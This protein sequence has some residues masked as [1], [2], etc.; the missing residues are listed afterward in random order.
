MT[1]PNLLNDDGTASMATMFMMS[2]HAFRRDL[3]CFSRALSKVAA[4][5]TSRVEAL[6]NE[7]QWYHG[8][9]HGHH[10]MEDGNVFPGM[11]KEHPELAATIERLSSDHHK[12]DPILERG[13]RAFAELP[14]TDAAIGVVNELIE[15]LEPHL[16]LEE[17]EIVPFLRQAKAF[18]A[19]PTE[20]EAAMYAQGFAWSLHGIAPQ[21]VAEVYK[22]LP[23]ALTSRLPEARA[24]FGERC[25][26]AWGSAEA[27]ASLTPIPAS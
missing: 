25:V 6:R 10:G 20:A 1:A 3:R 2:H 13:D 21:V 22:L 8:A 7:W 27:G 9:L 12:I 23:E 24:Q 14:K 19:P 18:P 26:K 4:G 11:Q 16:A 15:L 17:A 5:D